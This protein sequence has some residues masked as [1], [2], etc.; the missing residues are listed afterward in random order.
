MKT[1]MQ[2]LEYNDVQADLASIIE[3]YGVRIFLEDFARNY[4]QHFG[5]LV[6]RFHP[7]QQ[8]KVPRLMQQYPDVK[9]EG[10]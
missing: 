8:A 3:Q 1:E 2:Q 4:P 6:N 7:A 9:S 10:G 5:E